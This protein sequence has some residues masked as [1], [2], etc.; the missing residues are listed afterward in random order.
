MQHRSYPDEPEFDD[1]M[2]DIDDM[3]DDCG[4]S[5]RGMVGGPGDSE[6]E[7]CLDTNPGNVFNALIKSD[8]NDTDDMGQRNLTTKALMKIVCSEQ[9]KMDSPAWC[10]RLARCAMH[11][12]TSE[13]DS[14][15][16][17]VRNDAYRRDNETRRRKREVNSHQN[18]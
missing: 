11:S 8:M 14:L 18:K 15:K 10:E 7:T 4:L 9:K 12:V 13:R 17:V 1:I 16:E 5:R 2:I 6:I 3:A